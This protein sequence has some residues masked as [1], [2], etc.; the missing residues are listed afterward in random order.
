MGR[1]HG[2]TRSSGASSKSAAPKGN[3]DP[4]YGDVNIVK[5]NLMRYV[6]MDKWNR[7]TDYQMGLNDM[8]Q[9]IVEDVAK[10]DYGVATDIAQRAVNSP[11]WNKY[12]YNLSEKQAY[13]V[14]KA[15]VE[16]GHVPRDNMY[17]KSW[18][19]EV[20]AAEARKEAA[21]LQK[22]N[23]YSASYTRSST[24]VAVGSRVHDSKKGWGTISGIITKSSGYVAVKYDS[25]STGKA[26]AFNL[27]GEDGNPLKKRPK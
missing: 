12:G 27:T 20:K 4:D 7:N 25:G 15:A 3:F 6:P 2:G 9:G 18:H 14:A 13:V 17:S 8:A 1:G 26:M 10:G 11:N 19:A 5:D 21:R 16:H 24:K 22:W 23:D